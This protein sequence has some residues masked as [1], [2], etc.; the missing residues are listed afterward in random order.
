MEA[1]VRIAT[2]VVAI[3]G[4]AVLVGVV[5]GVID[6]AIAVSLRLTFLWL[7]HLANRWLCLWGEHEYATV[8][9]VDRM[10]VRCAHCHKE[11][12]GVPLPPAPLVFAWP[13][14]K[15]RQKLL[16]WNRGRLLA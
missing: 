4:T 3:L 16:D 6:A 8:L 9:D 2:W 13:S 15:A 5:F 12:P 7:E 14:E 11:S 10:F 1:F